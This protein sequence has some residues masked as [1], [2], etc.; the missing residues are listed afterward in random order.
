MKGCK[1]HIETC[2]RTASIVP[3]SDLRQRCRPVLQLTQCPANN[4][5]FPPAA[6]VFT[7]TVC[8]AQNRYR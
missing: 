1:Q 6:V 7:V 8:S 3:L 4:A 2:A 5:A